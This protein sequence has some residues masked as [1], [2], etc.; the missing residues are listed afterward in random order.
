MKILS[1][2]ILANEF[3]AR[4]YYP[5][6]PSNVLFK[7]S[8]RLQKIIQ[9][10]TLVNADVMLLQEVMLSEYN[11]LCS[12][13]S[14]KYNIIRSKP[15]IWQNERSH[16]YNVTLL[17]NSLFSLRGAEV[18]FMDF[19]LM[20][21]STFTKNYNIPISII[22]VHLDD[23]SHAKRKQQ[24]R[25]LEPFLKTYHNIILG[26]DFN[27]NYTASSPLY[28]SIKSSGLKIMNDKPTYYIKRKVCIDNIMLKGAAPHPSVDVINDFDNNIVNQFIAYGS[29]HLP[30]IVNTRGR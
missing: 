16:S 3:I 20:V 26:G 17:N 2:N 5:M 1:W 15:I 14:S 19:G 4:R 29:D 24:I 12:Q 7:R 9:T 30:L 23:L 13:F 8:E 10:L 6:I 28:K 18:K 11:A 25:L 22:N 27:E 21:N